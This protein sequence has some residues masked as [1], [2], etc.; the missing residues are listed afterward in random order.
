MN[1][2]TK[3]HENKISRLLLMLTLVLGIFTFSGFS[4]N[5]R[6]VVDQKATQTEVGIG[7]FRQAGGRSISF[8]KALGQL[9]VDRTPCPQLGWKVALLSFDNLIKVKLA[10]IRAHPDFQ[11]TIC[12]CHLTRM[13]PQSSDEEEPF[14]V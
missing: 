1:K 12:R 10:R 6:S 7:I 5:T 8:G 3:Y 11:R 14:S 4:V 13:I 2:N 9:S